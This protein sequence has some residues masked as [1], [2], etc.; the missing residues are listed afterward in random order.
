MDFCDE[1]DIP[2]QRCGKLVVA[3]RPDELAR[4]EQL[5]QRGVANGVAGLEPVDE[6]R[7]RDI[8]PHATGLRALYSPNSSIVDY[9]QVAAAIATEVQTKG[10]VVLT[11]ARVTS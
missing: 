1:N 5:H 11:G 2:F 6:Q 8:E 7:I 10:G 4:L 3:T 9:G